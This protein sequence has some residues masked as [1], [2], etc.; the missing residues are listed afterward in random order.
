MMLKNIYILFY[1]ILFY[2]ILFY[3]ILYYSKIGESRSL[4]F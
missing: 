4:N 2:S 3:S 1:S